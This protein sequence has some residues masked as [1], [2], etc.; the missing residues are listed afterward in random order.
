MSIRQLYLQ[1]AMWIFLM[2][3]FLDWHH[4]FQ[5]SVSSGDENHRI[6]SEVESQS[7]IYK[8]LAVE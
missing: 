5:Q 1:I 3:R 8:F 6:V 2:P 4:R 7:P